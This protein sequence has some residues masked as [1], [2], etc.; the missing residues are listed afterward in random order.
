MTGVLTNLSAVWA[1]ARGIIPAVTAQILTVRNSLAPASE[2]LAVGSSLMV[3]TALLLVFA[4]VVSL[5][6]IQFR[7]ALDGSQAETCSARLNFLANASPVN[8]E[9]DK[10][11]D[12]DCRGF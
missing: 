11:F 7:L 1:H 4:Y 8:P 10:Q 3:K 9:L 6:M 5:E 12:K 2:R